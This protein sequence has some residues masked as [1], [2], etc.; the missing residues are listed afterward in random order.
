MH[1]PAF[2]VPYFNRYVDSINLWLY[3]T[4][5]LTILQSNADMTLDIFQIFSEQLFTRQLQPVTVI[6]KLSYVEKQSLAK[7][8]LKNFTKFTEKH[9]CR[10]KVVGLRGATLLKKKL[11]HMCFPVNSVKYLRKP[12]VAAAVF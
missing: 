7:V 12:S 5:N 11:W 9:V 2:A 3:R 1:F 8:V 10:S 4:C 6:H